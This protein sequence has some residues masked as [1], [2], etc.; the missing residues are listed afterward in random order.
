VNIK[1][2][3]LATALALFAAGPAAASVNIIAAENFYG[4]IAR[5]IGGNNVSVI[6]I[7]NNPDQDPHLFEVSP[8]V[9]REVSTAAIVVYS[10]LDYDQWMPD[11]LAASP[12]TGRQVIVV[13]P[14]GGHRG[15]DN[16]HVWYDVATMEGYAEK[17]AAA[18]AAED[19]AHAAAYQSNL[20]AFQQSLAPLNARI[21]A[22]RTRL[23]GLPVAAT[24]PVFGY[25]AAALGLDVGDNGFQLAVMN[26]TEPS[27]RQIAGI[28]KDLRD[29]RVKLLIYNS[30][31]SDTTADR[32]RRIALA[33]HVPLL[34]VTETEPAGQ[35]YQQWMTG[36][37]AALAQA[38]PVS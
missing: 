25:M 30:Q 32:M 4:D 6:S 12:A 37:L 21:A 24:E 11:L 7:L 17:L 15:G 31:A 29:H 38:L 34:A 27:A 28:E 35:D 18:L 8:S 9:G 16:P 33:S 10:G 2:L 14:L 1:N 26:G 20:A 22:L 13:A 5:Q 19:P 23:A 3:W 36:A